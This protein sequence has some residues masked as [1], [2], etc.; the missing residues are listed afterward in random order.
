[1]FYP[2]SLSLVLL[3]VSCL[4]RMEWPASS[5][6]FN[7]IEHLWDQLGH[8]VCLVEEWDAIPEQCVI[9]LVTSN[10]HEEEVLGCCVWFFHMLLRPRLLNQ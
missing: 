2:V 9:K 8:A 6:D 7:P 10:Q 4:E 3:E 1:V 5:P